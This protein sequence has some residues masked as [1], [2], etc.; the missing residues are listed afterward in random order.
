M[1]SILF[2]GASVSQVGAIR[3]ARELGIRVVAVDGDPDALGFTDAD[4]AENIDFSDLERVIEV[5]RRN[6]ID[7]VVA[8]STDRAVPIAA[9][10]ATALGLPGIGIETATMM[11]NKAAMRTR[12]AQAGVSQPTFAVLRAG[13]DL[14]A[15]LKMVGRPA[16]L[17]PI[18]SGGQRGV[19]VVETPDQL[20][21]SWPITLSHSR[22]G[23]AI[24]E[25]YI[26][27]S[28]LN[29]IAI[30]CDGE[31]HLL[32]LSDRLRPEGQGFGVGWAHL[33]PSTLSESTLRLVGET[34]VAAIRALDL[35]DGIAFPQI[36]ATRDEAFVVE[37]AARIPA[38]Q[39]ADLVRLG[40]GV[41][42]IEIAFQQAFGRPIDEATRLPQFQRP[43]AIRFLTASP[44][45][46][47]TGLVSS[48]AGLET[49]R[50]SAGVLE[51]GLYLRLGETINA[52]HVDQ[53][54]RGYIAATGRDS[55]E[56][57]ELADAA[58]RKLKIGI[59]SGLTSGLSVV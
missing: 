38:G 43:V 18:D 54:R 11:T 50:A 26:E 44:G 53:D 28:E 58:A 52:V 34:A 22:S 56:A 9:A 51:A 31:P 30:V 24:L 46:L 13:D 33:Y 3:R 12:L 41:D 4:V 15:A 2:I 25:R 10:V 6:Q 27:G 36:L 14:T 55:R 23:E 20:R 42:L 32:T 19:F 1:N 8:I 16:V 5:G 37:V 47:P 49:V 21:E 17:K 45:V 35:R 40:T 7:G 57:L 59:E 39:M 48:I 29:G